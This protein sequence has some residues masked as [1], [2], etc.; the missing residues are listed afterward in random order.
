MQ[1]YLKLHMI[2]DTVQVLDGNTLRVN[3]A[4]YPKGGG[5]PAASRGAG[6]APPGVRGR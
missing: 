4:K 3:V 1:S 6:P 5:P 2:L